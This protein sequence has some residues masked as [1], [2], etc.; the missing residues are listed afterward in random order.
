MDRFCVNEIR[1][2]EMKGDSLIVKVQFCE[3]CDGCKP[4][5]IRFVDL[6]DIDDESDYLYSPYTRYMNG[7]LVDTQEIIQID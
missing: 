2:V 1:S 7:K 6:A 3:E 5:R 4:R